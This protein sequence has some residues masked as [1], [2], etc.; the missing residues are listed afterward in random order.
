[1]KPPFKIGDKVKLTR[2]KF[3][4]E[5][6]DLILDKL[7]DLGIFEHTIYTISEI[8]SWLDLDHTWYIHLAEVDAI[9]TLGGLHSDLFENAK[10]VGFIIE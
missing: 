2:N 10:S 4:I 1:M 6:T 7:T 9:K 8:S 3:D 5:E